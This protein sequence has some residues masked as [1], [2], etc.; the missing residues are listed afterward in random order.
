M[1]EAESRSSSKIMVERE[2]M[3]MMHEMKLVLKLYRSVLLFGY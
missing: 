2:K 3:I 1:R